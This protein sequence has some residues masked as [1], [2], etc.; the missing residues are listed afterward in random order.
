MR[1]LDLSSLRRPV[2][3]A[4]QLARFTEPEFRER[5]GSFRDVVTIEADCPPV[6]LRRSGQIFKSEIGD[7]NGKIKRVI[8]VP[9]SM[10]PLG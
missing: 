6:R 1:E 10:V 4:P 7:F 2:Q 3:A 9:V 5:F 8:L